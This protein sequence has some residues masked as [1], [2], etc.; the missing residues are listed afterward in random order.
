VVHLCEVSRL[1]QSKTCAYGSHSENLDCLLSTVTKA[2]NPS[3][4]GIEGL[5]AKE[6]E[7]TFVIV[8]KSVHPRAKGSRKSIKGE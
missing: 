7:S 5:V 2:L 3:L 8:T 1:C 4:V 6:T